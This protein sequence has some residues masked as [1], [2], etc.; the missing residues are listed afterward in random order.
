MSSMKKKIGIIGAG[1]VGTT[2]AYSLIIN[3]IP[4]DIFL[5]DI[6][7][8]R[9]HGEFLDLSDTLPFNTSSTTIHVGT[10]KEIQTADIIIIAAG[11]KQEPGQSRHALLETNQKIIKN[12]IHPLLPLPS[13]TILIMVTNPVDV[14]TRYAL[15]ISKLPAQQVFGSGTYLDS[16][17]LRQ[18]I[19][20]YLQVSP[21]SV[22]VDIYGEHGDSQFVAWSTAMINSIPLSL[23]P[24]F[25]Y[26]EFVNLAHQVR[27]RAYEIIKCKGSTFYGIAT[28][29]TDICKMIIFDQKKVIPVSVYEKKSDICYSIPC[30]ISAKGIEQILPLSINNQEFEQLKNSI[31]IIQFLW[32]TANK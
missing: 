22:Q 18:F 15:E 6:D 30:V 20:N 5:V 10:L 24:Q 13:S 29:I 8:A 2:I 1:A 16:M 21:Q 23:L 9:C 3:N 25:N 28:C 17:R 32:Q 12:I 26:Q 27:T 7:K 14:L 4:A 11:K 19:G 31:Q